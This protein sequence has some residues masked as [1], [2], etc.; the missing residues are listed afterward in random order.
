VLQ[1]VVRHQ[2]TRLIRVRWLLLEL[3]SHL[4]RLLM[5]MLLPTSLLGLQSG[6]AV[7]LLGLPAGPLLCNALW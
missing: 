7:L 6:H 5:L 2:Q 1:Q 3:E 4:L